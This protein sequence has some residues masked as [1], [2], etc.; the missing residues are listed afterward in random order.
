MWQAIDKEMSLEEC[1]IYSYEPEDDPYDDDEDEPS[2][3]SYHYFFFNKAKKRVCYLHIRAL[4]LSSDVDGLRTPMTPTPVAPGRTID[5]SWARA[6]PGSAKRAKYW[7]GDRAVGNVIG[8]W[9]DEDDTNAEDSDHK[10]FTDTDASKDDSSL[11]ESPSP[12]LWRKTRNLEAI[13]ESGR[14]VDDDI[15][16]AIEL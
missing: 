5:L 8:G 13:R 10:G 14:E 9:D 16:D 4:S 7:L 1:I 12:D 15:A 3:W 2:I 11:S 6:E